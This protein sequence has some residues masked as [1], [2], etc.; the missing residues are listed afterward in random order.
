VAGIVRLGVLR[1]QLT[2]GCQGEG[3]QRDYGLTEVLGEFAACSRKS[4]A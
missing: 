2:I 3:D 1:P 4:C